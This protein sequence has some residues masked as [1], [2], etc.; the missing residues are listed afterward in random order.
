MSILN[1]NHSL[2]KIVIQ[3]KH[4]SVVDILK[5]RFAYFILQIEMPPITILVHL[6]NSPQNTC[7]GP[8]IQ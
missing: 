4:E 2:R 1:K 3:P 7:K 8:V 6:I 5:C